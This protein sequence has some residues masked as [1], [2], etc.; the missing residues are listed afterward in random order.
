[1]LL[2][3]TS[4]SRESKDTE[5]QDD[6]NDIIVFL[7]KNRN[8]ICNTN[9]GKGIYAIKLNKEEIEFYN[10]RLTYFINILKEDEINKKKYFEE[11]EY[12]MDKFRDDSLQFNDEGVFYWSIDIFDYR[13]FTLIE[14]NFNNIKFQ[15]KYIK[16]Y[17]M[18]YWMMV[19]YDILK[20]K[21]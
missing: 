19:N 15:V 5:N 6:Y 14:K 9:S 12:F 21:K 4:C 13:L 18:N 3:I 1:M 8:D 11:H 20:E 7:E 16:D 10:H 17:K 2:N